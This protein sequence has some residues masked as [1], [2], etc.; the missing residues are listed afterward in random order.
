MRKPVF[1]PALLEG[2]Q[3]LNN[4]QNK[5]LSVVC[6]RDS[7]RKNNEKGKCALEGK[8]EGGGCKVK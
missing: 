1:G 5:Q 6:G 7:P 4:N 3:M 2:K 8:V